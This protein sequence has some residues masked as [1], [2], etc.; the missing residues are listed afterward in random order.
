MNSFRKSSSK[1]NYSDNGHNIS[2]LDKERNSTFIGRMEES[3]TAMTNEFDNSF[4]RPMSSYV[5]LICIYCVIVSYKTFKLNEKWK[6]IR[7]CW[8]GYK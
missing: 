7:K 3:T 2:F 6:I 4:I 5:I 8:K 1:I